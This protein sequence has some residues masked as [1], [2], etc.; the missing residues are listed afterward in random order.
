M[1]DAEPTQPP[2]CPIDWWSDDGQQLPSAAASAVTAATAFAVGEGLEVG[3]LYHAQRLDQ[4]VPRM[5]AHI[6]GLVPSEFRERALAALAGVPAA[7][8]QSSWQVEY[9]LTAQ[10]G[11]R[12][13]T[14]LEVRDDG[15]VRLVG[16]WSPD[17]EPGDAADGRDR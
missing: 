15:T 2:I 5:E 12:L 10:G 17:S 7:G 6:A 8:R 1:G 13:H 11:R 16:Q 14:K 4:F 3:E 9:R